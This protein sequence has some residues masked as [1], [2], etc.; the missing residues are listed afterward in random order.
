MSNN[1]EFVRQELIRAYEIC[2]PRNQLPLEY[3]IR[4][5][6]DPDQWK[7]FSEKNNLKS[8]HILGE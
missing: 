7:E 8:Y 1:I 6:S 3:V 5:Y 4:M 2:E